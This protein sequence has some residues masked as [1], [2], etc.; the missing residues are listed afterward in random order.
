M[1]NDREEVGM[2]LSA[3]ADGE[4]DAAGRLEVEAR[5]A[6]DPEL[7]ARLADQHAFS[8]AF[9]LGVEDASAAVDFAAFTD[10]VMARL[11]PRKLGWGQLVRRAFAAL[12]EQRRYQVALGGLAAAAVAVI[13]TPLLLDDSGGAAIP[14]GLLF[15]GGP[16]A[17]DVI[18]M[19]PV[20]D[21]ETMLF[22]SAGGATIIFVQESR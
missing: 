3:Y 22:K 21:H 7:S 4:L 2:L 16:A 12:L 13:A 18:S 14:P 9:A 15:A 8:E 5:L 17:V 19:D 1:M 6:A 11:E 20:G 10:A